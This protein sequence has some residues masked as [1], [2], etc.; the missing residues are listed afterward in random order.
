MT[1]KTLEHKI[2]FSVI[3]GVKNANPN[4]DPLDNNRPRINAD[5][6]GEISD[7]A[8]KRKIR[9]RWQDMKLP[10]LIEMQERITDG[11]MNIRDRIKASEAI[12]E[13]LAEDMKKTPTWR[14]DFIKAATASWIDVR[15]FGQVMA[16]NNK[17]KDGLDG[18]SIPVRGPVSIQSAFSTE[19]IQVKEMQI[20]KSINS[21]PGVVKGSDTMGIK[22]TVPFAVYKFNGSINVEQAQRTGFTEDD[23]EALKKALTTLFVNDAS[24]A[25]PEGSMAVLKVIWWQHDSRIGQLAPYL[26][27]EATTVNNPEGNTDFS[28]VE[29]TVNDPEVSGLTYESLSGY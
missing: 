15:S 11:H 3:I 27:H 26:V 6:L 23:A 21:E 14:D 10:V 5:G 28:K 22:N 20:T 12:Q 9:N 2:D 8:I 19:P 16:F 1:S 4:G 24:S 29:V 18:A 13:I 7:V 25:R 17:T